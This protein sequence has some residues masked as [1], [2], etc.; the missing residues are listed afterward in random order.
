MNLFTLQFPDDY[1]FTV[2]TFYI[3]SRFPHEFKREMKGKLGQAKGII[4][5]YNS[6]LKFPFPKQPMVYWEKH[7]K[8]R[9]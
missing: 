6:C 8:G 4:L 7:G 5:S 9:F 3:H 1:M 2:R